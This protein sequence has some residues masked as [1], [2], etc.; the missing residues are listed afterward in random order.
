MHRLDP[1]AA[2]LFA[3]MRAWT[4]DRSSTNTITPL[5]PKFRDFCSR[6]CS[7]PAFSL[8][9]LHITHVPPTE[10]R[11]LGTPPTPRYLAI[12]GHTDHPSRVLTPATRQNLA[13]TRAEDSVCLI[14][15]PCRPVIR[16]LPCLHPSTPA[17]VST[18]MP[19]CITLTSITSNL[20]SLNAEVRLLKP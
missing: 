10:H 16:C 1:C 9:P 8:P 15:S 6:K 11:S 3:R 13:I 17:R 7:D 5:E 14:A 20:D 19:V 18:P 2:P 4:H 12:P